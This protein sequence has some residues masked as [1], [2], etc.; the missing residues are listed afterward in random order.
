M[1]AWSEGCENVY[2]VPLYWR[3]HAELSKVNAG[4]HM[5]VAAGDEAPSERFWLPRATCKTFTC[6]ALSKHLASPEMP[7][8]GEAFEGGQVTG[9]AVMMWEGPGGVTVLPQLD[10]DTRA[11]QAGLATSYLQAQRHKLRCAKP[12]MAR[13]VSLEVVVDVVGRETSYTLGLDEGG[14]VLVALYS[15]YTGLPIANQERTAVLVGLYDEHGSVVDGYEPVE[16]VHGDALVTQLLADGIDTLIVAAGAVCSLRAAVG[17]RNLTVL[18]VHTADELIYHMLPELVAT[19]PLIFSCPPS[20]LD[21]F[22]LPA[23]QVG[24][25]TSVLIASGPDR[26]LRMW[27]ASR[28][29]SHLIKYVCC[30]SA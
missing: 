19:P 14:A 27:C 29:A 6:H 13:W 15:A 22:E 21:V 9:M 12:G 1:S 2:E 20:Q 30:V 17:A 26:Q 18:G 28:R 23:A 25:V 24:A 11:G 8:M 3:V 7:P 10:E 5:A 4:G 16:V